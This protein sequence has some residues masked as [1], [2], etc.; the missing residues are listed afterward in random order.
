MADYA[1]ILKTATDEAQDFINNP[2][3]LDQLLADLE[4]KLADVPAIGSTLS[5]LP[6]TISLVKSW[7]KKEYQV[8]PKVLAT[9]VGAFLYLVKKKDLIPDS[10]PVIGIAD[11]VAVVGLA[12]KFVEPDLKAYKDWKAHQ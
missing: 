10:I 9:L 12:L 8:S 4:S 6:V 2:S 7:I 1:Q 11:D 3:R 5:E